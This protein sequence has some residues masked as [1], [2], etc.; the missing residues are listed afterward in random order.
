ML[1]QYDAIISGPVTPSITLASMSF[2]IF[3]AS[4]KFFIRK[5]QCIKKDGV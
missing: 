5:T 3:F 1:L 2:A 4:I